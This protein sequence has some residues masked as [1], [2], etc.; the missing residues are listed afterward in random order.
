MIL[1]GDSSWNESQYCKCASLSF[2]SFIY[3]QLIYYLLCPGPQTS[4]R[5]ASEG[6]GS[7]RNRDHHRRRRPGHRDERRHRR[8]CGGSS[9]RSV[10]NTSSQCDVFTSVLPNSR[11]PSLLFSL[12]FGTR[13]TCK[14]GRYRGQKVPS[15]PL[16]VVVKYGKNTTKDIPA[17]YQY[18][19]NPKITDYYPKASFLWWACFKTSGH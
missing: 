1:D 6:S 17:A 4:L 12:S 5:P 18:S 19:E 7:R 11:S 16:T 2:L 8:H 15:D 13:I 14:T 9:L 10:S 3:K